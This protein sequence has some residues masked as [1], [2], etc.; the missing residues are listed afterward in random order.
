[1][2]CRQPGSEQ[3][4]ALFTVRQTL[5]MQQQTIGILV[6]G[7]LTYEAPNFEYLVTCVLPADLTGLFTLQ[8]RLIGVI[9][10]YENPDV[11]PP[12]EAPCRDMEVTTSWLSNQTLGNVFIVKDIF[13]NGSVSPDDPTQAVEPQGTFW[14]HNEFLYVNEVHVN[15]RPATSGVENVV[16]FNVLMLAGGNENIPPT[17]KGGIVTVIEGNQTLKGVGSFGEAPVFINALGVPTI[18]RFAEVIDL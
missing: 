11:D 18:P 12:I 14:A 16:S 4:T 15:V 9:T 13:C 1:L 8:L 3:S 7:Q 6:E 2:S 5:R 17:I 10:D